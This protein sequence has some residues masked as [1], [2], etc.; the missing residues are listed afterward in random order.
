MDIKVVVGDI[1]EVA[2]DA[3]VVNL[4]QGVE[5]PGGATGA[6]DMALDGAISDLIAGRRDHRQEGQH[7]VIHTLG[8][9][10]AKR[11]VVAGLGKADNFT[12]NTIRDV[13][14]DTAR[15]L[16]GLG[17]KRKRRQSCTGQASAAS[18]RRKRRRRSPRAR[19]SACTPSA[20]T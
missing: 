2:V 11:V 4:F 5:A 10:P 15:Y 13:A 8:K 1:T 19:F 17:I 7:A 20:S 16:R 18:T 6:V 3:I 12:V 9:M 14:G